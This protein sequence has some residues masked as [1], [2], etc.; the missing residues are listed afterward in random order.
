MTGRIG[1]R[2][3]MAQHG[4]SSIR[5]PYYNV[6]VEFPPPPNVPALLLDSYLS[7][8]SHLLFYTA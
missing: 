6:P 4:T 7:F 3:S 8:F 2:A 5:A 1:D